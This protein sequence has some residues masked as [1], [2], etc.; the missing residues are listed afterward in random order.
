L[1]TLLKQHISIAGELVAAAAAGNT[2]KA[3]AA[4]KRWHDNAVAIATFLSGANPNWPQAT[5]VDML[6]KH[7]MLTS[8]EATARI[9]KNWT[10]DQMTFDQIFA[11]A[12]EMADA[13][14]A[15]IIAQFPTKV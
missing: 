10:Q 3:T 7:L 2:T 6:N 11:Q 5:L 12:M 1:T 4:D 14:S 13:L 8:Q 9:K 15:G